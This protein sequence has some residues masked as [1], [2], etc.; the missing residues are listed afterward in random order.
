MS[1]PI[2]IAATLDASGGA[3]DEISQ[4][5][6]LSTDAAA[7]HVAVTGGA[8]TG[9]DIHVETRLADDLDW[10]ALSPSTTG[11][12]SGYN[13]LDTFD[14]ADLDTV[15]VRIVNQDTTAGNTADVRGVLTT[16]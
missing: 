6:A 3:N 16:R 2:D 12:T 7:V 11:V 8:S 14:V 1:T 13:S 10:V 9:V 15:R 4:Q 5:A